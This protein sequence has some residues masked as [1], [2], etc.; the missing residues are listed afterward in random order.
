MERRLRKEQFESYNKFMFIIH[1]EMADC[2]QWL[3]T[4]LLPSHLATNFDYNLR[5][6]A[7]TYIRRMSYFDWGDVPRVLPL[8]ASERLSL[9]CLYVDEICAEGSRCIC[10]VFVKVHLFRQHMND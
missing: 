1:G 6:K 2:P 7:C 3:A 5:F 10:R 4:M 8:Y 9:L